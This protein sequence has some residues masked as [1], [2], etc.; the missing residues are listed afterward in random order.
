MISMISLVPLALGP[1]LSTVVAA[2]LIM[3]QSTVLPGDQI[4]PAIALAMSLV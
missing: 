4:G 1:G 3:M 2:P